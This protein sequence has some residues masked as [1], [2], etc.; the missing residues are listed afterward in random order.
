MHANG[1]IATNKQPPKGTACFFS[2]K[3]GDGGGHVG[4]IDINGKVVDTGYGLG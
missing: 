2:A 3:C 1:Y 4:L